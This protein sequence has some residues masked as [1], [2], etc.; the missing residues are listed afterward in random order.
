MFNCAISE[1][2]A[3]ETHSTE[4]RRD[5]RCSAR[6]A[7]QAASSRARQDGEGRRTPLAGA[8]AAVLPRLH[9]RTGRFQ[10]AHSTERPHVLRRRL[11]RRPLYGGGADLRAPRGRRRATAFRDATGYHCR[12]MTQPLSSVRILDLTSGVSGPWCTKL[13]ADYGADVIKV[14]RPGIGDRVA[15]ARPLPGRRPALARRARCSSGS[16]PAS[17]AS[18]STSRRRPAASSRCVSPR[19]A[20]PSSLDHRPSELRRL[21]L[22][23][24]D[25]AAANARIVTTSV[26][27]FGQSG[28]YAD[29]LATNLTSYASGGQHY[30]TGDAGPRA[31]AERRLPGA[32]PGRHLGL[33]RD[34]R[35][36]V[37]RARKTGV[38]Q[39]AEVCGQEVMASI[40]EI[41]LPDFAYRKAETLLAAPRQHVAPPPSASI[42]V[43][44]GHIGIHAMP[45]N[46]PQLIDAHGRAVDGRGRALRRQP[47]PPPQRRRADRADVTSWTAGVTKAEAYERGGTYRA[48]ISPVNTVADLLASRA[49]QRA[50]LLPRRRTS[51]PPARCATPARRPHARARQPSSAPPHSSASTTP[52]STASCSASRP[53][54]CR[55]S[56]RQA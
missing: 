49:P 22:T 18:R 13:L 16:T 8:G 17:A 7:A 47:R 25:F 4:R 3:A 23:H 50:Q 52:R 31:A 33:R 40:L 12:H 51:A 45:K 6:R 14:E 27:A 2:Y 48:P 42:P 21:R 35:R 36:H 30:L 15:R 19:S 37:G 5:R 10:G 9:P 20:T 26:T 11:S 43:I 46:W 32:V 41:Y 54:I 29:W 1:A 53:A 34:A 39:Q 44:D 55:H 28:P 38:G 24:D 56:Q